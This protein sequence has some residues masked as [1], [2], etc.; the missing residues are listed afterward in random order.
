ML[1]PRALRPAEASPKVE[2]MGA[3]PTLTTEEPI[4]EENKYVEGKETGEK[5]SDATATVDDSTAD[6]R[7]IALALSEGYDL[8]LPKNQKQIRHPQRLFHQLDKMKF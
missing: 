1:S 4:K 8:S 7:A 6:D 3:T 5:V 2:E